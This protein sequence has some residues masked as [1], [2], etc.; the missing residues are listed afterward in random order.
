MIARSVFSS[1]CGGMRKSTRR[2]SNDRRTRHRKHRCHR[3]A[4]SGRVRER[5]VLGRV[6][7]A[8][9]VR[10]RG[11]H[12]IERNM[13]INVGQEASYVQT[14]LRNTTLV[15]YRRRRSDRPAPSEKSV[16]TGQDARAS[17]GQRSSELLL[18]M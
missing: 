14:G 7:V 5:R 13:S 9:N 3:P 16:Y 10:L 11:R 17:V 1:M 6:N 4:I 2:L 15:S 8:R 18:S 12:S